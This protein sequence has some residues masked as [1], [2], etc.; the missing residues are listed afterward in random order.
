[1]ATFTPSQYRLQIDRFTAD[2]ITAAFRLTY[3][4]MHVR[5]VTIDGLQKKAGYVGKHFFFLGYEALIDEHTS[6]LTFASPPRNTGQR[7]NIEVVY[8]YDPAVPAASSSSGSGIASAGQQFYA[9]YP[10]GSTPAAYG[11]RTP[12][13]IK[14][15]EVAGW[16]E[17]DYLDYADFE[18]ATESDQAIPYALCQW[19][20]R[21]SYGG[22]D[23]A[24]T[25][26]EWH[27]WYD[28]A[29]DHCPRFAREQPRRRYR[30]SARS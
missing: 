29:L 30:L 6:S 28:Y 19:L 5:S 22:D 3:K 13:K 16:K 1:M 20:L 8:V 11:G 26:S 17:S 9:M 25:V 27:A 18:T 4:P 23:D 14:R 15:Q 10:T 21:Q 7:N 12:E 24:F 2:G